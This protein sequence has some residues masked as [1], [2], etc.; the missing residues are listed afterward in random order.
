M[1]TKTVN[2]RH[3]TNPTVSMAL[4]RDMKIETG[5]IAFDSSY[6]TGGESITFGF[7]PAVVIVESKAGYVFSYDYTNEKVLAYLA[8]YDAAADGVLIQVGNATN[9]SALTDVR[10]VAIGW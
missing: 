2:V 8:D 5:T 7:T 6:P 4:S 10:Y 3:E 1:A 9:L